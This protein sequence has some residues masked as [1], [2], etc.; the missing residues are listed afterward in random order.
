MST[1][2]WELI[3]KHG[4]RKHHLYLLAG[5]DLSKVDVVVTDTDETESLAPIPAAVLLYGYNYD[6]DF[7][8]AVAYG[9]PFSLFAGAG[10]SW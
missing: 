6:A 7:S 9:T 8:F 10:Y 1:K 5:A 4:Y 3:P 2:S